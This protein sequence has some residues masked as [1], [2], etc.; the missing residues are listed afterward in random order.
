MVK[1]LP[2]NAGAKEGT[3]LIPGSARSH[4]GGD[5]NPLLYSCPGKSHGHRSP[6]GYGPWDRPELDTTKAIEHSTHTSSTN[7]RL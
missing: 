7:M 2:D 3:G 1:N 5:G 6:V 4:G